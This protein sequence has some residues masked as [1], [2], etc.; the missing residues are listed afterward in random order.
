MSML[1]NSEALT[2]EQLNV[3]TQAWVEQGYNHHFHEEIKC[4]PVERFMSG[5]SVLR[6][7]VDMQTLQLAFSKKVNRKQRKSD[8]TI[9]LD[10]VR[11]EIPNHLR[12]LDNISIRYRS[13]D[14]SFATIVDRRSNA[15]LAK[16]R[17]IDKQKNANCLRRPLSEP[18]QASYPKEIKDSE[19]VAP[20][21]EQMLEDYS[22][23]GL[24][25]AYLP[26]IEN[27]H[28]QKENNDVT[29]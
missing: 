21:L 22:A 1:E 10:G 5:P 16:I 7:S 2:L 17:P 13:W 26:K 12:T 8:G 11:F 14:L 6:P 9:T 20:L 28:K 24:P 15:E 19:R 18:G 29:K 27:I 4:T 3:Y 23:T 25:P